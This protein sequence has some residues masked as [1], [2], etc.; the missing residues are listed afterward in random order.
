[1]EEEGDNEDDDEED[2]EEDCDDDDE[3]DNE[4]IGNRDSFIT[5]EQE[6]GKTENP[7][8]SSTCKSAT[9]VSKDVGDSEGN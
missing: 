4:N 2:N 5:D 3:D 6:N 7:S 1:M 8:L 9:P